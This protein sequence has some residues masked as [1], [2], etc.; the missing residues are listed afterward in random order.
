MKLNC[1]VGEGVSS[2]RAV[3]PFIG[4]ANIACG[5]HAGDADLMIET[6]KIAKVNKVQIGAHPGYNDR[7][8]FGRVP[9]SLTSEQVKHLI[10]YQV[11]AL[12]CL[13]KLHQVSV[14]Y[15]KPHGAL[16]NEM[17]VNEAVFCAIVEALCQFEK[18]LKLMIL[19][20]PNLG[21]YQQ[22]AQQHGVTL[23]LEAFADRAY[24][25]AG[26]L[27]KRGEKGALL[28][29]AEMVEKQVKQLIDT[30]TIT[31]INGK[32][33]HLQVDSICVHGDNPI[34]VKQIE[35]LAMLIQ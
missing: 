2:D 10:C 23:I 5:F 32:T 26:Y 34:A 15:V 33:I 19:A 9:I 24:D 13:A 30:Q 1:D 17:M 14:S 29:S 28:A 6:I 25:D 11:G 4:Q 20:H 35:N 8:N 7:I 16:Y 31:T 21:N 22:I 12:Q 18:P 3:M 27:V